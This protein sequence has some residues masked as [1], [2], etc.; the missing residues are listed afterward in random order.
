MVFRVV[1]QSITVRHAYF[2]AIS[3]FVAKSFLNK[4]SPEIISLYTFP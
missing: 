4:V 2:S 1:Y 3:R